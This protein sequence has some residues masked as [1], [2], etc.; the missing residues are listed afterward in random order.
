[1]FKTAKSM[2]VNS[3]NN[4]YPFPK[5]LVI[6]SLSLMKL[7]DML[8]KSYDMKYLLTYRLNQD[9][10]EHFFASARQMGACNEHPSPISFKHRVRAYL[11]YRESELVTNLQNIDKENNDVSL[12]EKSFVEL[13]AGQE[14]NIDNELCLSAMLFTNMDIDFELGY[15]N[16]EYSDFEESEVS[17][18]TV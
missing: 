11:F 10:L 8:K 2:N 4:I 3:R 5:G 7:Y 12:T 16:N 18:E 6:S 14:E 9:G 1:M 15:E 17:L 13:N